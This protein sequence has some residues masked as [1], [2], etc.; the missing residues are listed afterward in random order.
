[1]Q[2]Q[3]FITAKV[4]IRGQNGAYLLVG[5]VVPFATTPTKAGL[6]ACK[7]A[8]KPESTGLYISA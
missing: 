8:Y 1:M 4:I 3:A 5:P 6:G 2:L 7:G